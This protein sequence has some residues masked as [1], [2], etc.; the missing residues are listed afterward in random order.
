[1]AHILEVVVAHVIDAEDEAVLVLG[2][3]LTNVGKEP[4]LC[5]TTLLVHLGKVVDAG[6][7][8]LG[9]CGGSELVSL[10]T[11]VLNENTCQLDMKQT[12]EQ[13]RP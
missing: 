4:F 5:L 6:A 1:M 11:V 13:K 9:H 7:F 12:T 10:L 2:N 3:G 8:G